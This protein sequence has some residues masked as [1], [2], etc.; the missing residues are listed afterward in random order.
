MTYKAKL[1]A[2]DSSETSETVEH[3]TESNSYWPMEVAEKFAEHH[4]PLYEIMVEI[5]YDPESNEWVALTTV[6]NGKTYKLVEV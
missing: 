1:Y 4:A 6:F 2:H 3:L 5:E